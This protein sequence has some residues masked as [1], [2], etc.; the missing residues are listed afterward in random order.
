ML[1]RSVGTAI[2]A[3]CN[4]TRV[5]QQLS[6]LGGLPLVVLAALIAFGVIHVTTRLTVVLGVVL[7]AVDL[8]GWRF[9]SLMFDRERLITG[10]KS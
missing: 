1:F 4:D 2:S 7:L 10:T 9:V 5:A 6:V 3:R 8:R